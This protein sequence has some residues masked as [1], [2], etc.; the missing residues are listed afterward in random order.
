[1]ANRQNQIRWRKSDADDL[2][3]AINNYNAKLY[4]E[5][6]KNPQAKEYLPERVKF[7][8]VKNSITTRADYN[9]AIGSFKQITNKNSALSKK[10]A[11]Y[12]E[13]Q[14]TV[15]QFNAKI[16]KVSKTN[17]QAKD[18][19][20]DKVDF[21]ELKE[22]LYKNRAIT[23][24]INSHKRF[25]K[26]G[27]E[28]LIKSSRSA[29]TTKWELNEFK[30]KERADNARR[31]KELKKLQEQG[32]TSRGEPVMGT[33]EENS[34]KPRHTN[35]DNLSQKEWELKKKNIDKA[36]DPLHEEFR[37][38]NMRLNYVKGLRN[39]GFSEDIVALV[40]NMDINKF[41]E[42]VYTD[43]EAD[44]DFIYDEAE[45]N[46]KQE[47]LFEVWERASEGD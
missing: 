22:G 39:A 9:K 32:K 17:P 23:Q 10:N 5:I 1:M 20:P 28:T 26:E 25:L 36:L 15:K 45:F 8:E 27:A 44:F 40:M 2:K 13:L 7:S 37:K 16:D 18:Y 19:L 46:L 41:I 21:K 34:L 24:A 35:F 29:K 14:K 4:R 38:H 43:T 6:K 30:I 33:I 3:R 31:T 47:A 42:T 11:L 12:K